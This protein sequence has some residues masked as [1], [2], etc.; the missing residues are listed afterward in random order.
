MAKTEGKHFSFVWYA[1]IIG[2]VIC[3]LPF[4]VIGW[5][6]W[7]TQVAHTDALLM[8]GMFLGAELSAPDAAEDT[9]GTMT[10]WIY[11]RVHEKLWRVLIGIWLAG[12][13]IWRIELYL[14]LLF[15]AWLP[16]HY[17]REGII[18]PVDKAIRWIGKRL[19]IK[20]RTN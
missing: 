6:P 17:S 11:S 13:I 20:L 3:S 19:G 5:L 15:L 18:G 1:L 7:W 8:F 10:N 14:G 4:D 9:A 2:A 16:I 12:L